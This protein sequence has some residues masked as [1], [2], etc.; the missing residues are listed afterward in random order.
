MAAI[1]TLI[2]MMQIL[3]IMKATKYF[4]GNVGGLDD[5]QMI[6][7]QS[8]NGMVSVKDSH[9]DGALKKDYPCFP[10]RPAMQSQPQRKDEKHK[11]VYLETGYVNLH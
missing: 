11:I 10:P 8:N 9:S 2:A 4:F 5:S 6:P 1:A 3:I 7:Q